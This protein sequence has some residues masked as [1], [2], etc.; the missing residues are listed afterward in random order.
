MSKIINLNL[1][2]NMNLIDINVVTRLTYLSYSYI[3]RHK[4]VKKKNIFNENISQAKSK[5]KTCEM[6]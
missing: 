2:L 3:K 4:N 5:G 1:Y 6:E